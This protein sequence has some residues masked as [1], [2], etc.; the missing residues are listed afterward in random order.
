M[1]PAGYLLV[2]NFVLLVA[3]PCV[4]DAAIISVFN[5]LVEETR[6]FADFV[7]CPLD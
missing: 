2:F 5:A 6:D 4:F 7:I 1:V 3:K